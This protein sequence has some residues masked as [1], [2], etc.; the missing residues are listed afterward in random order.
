MSA[1]PVAAF[2]PTRTAS[3]AKIEAVSPEAAEAFLARVEQRPPGDVDAALAALQDDGSMIGI[4]VLSLGL[5]GR[6]HGV[7]AVAPDRR[8][9][10][11]GSD[12][13]HAL[14]IA[15][16]NRGHSRLHGSYRVGDRASDALVRS[17]GMGA[18]VRMLHG[19]VTVMLSFPASTAASAR[20]SS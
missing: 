20:V 12:L 9:L 5:G 19:I 10:Q 14:V 17:A 7:V 8:R 6:V 1:D 4:A 2:A 18:T 3:G 16:A 13:L 11:V 15:A